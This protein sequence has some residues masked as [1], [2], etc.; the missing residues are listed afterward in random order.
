LNFVCT[1]C[2]GGGILL[3]D[4]TTQT[5]DI[6][7]DYKASQ[8]DKNSKTL[9][10]AVSD[11]HLLVGDMQLQINHYYRP[12]KNL[13]TIDSLL[14]VHPTNE[15]PILLMLQ[16]TRSTEKHDVKLSGL[17]RVNQM[18]LPPPREPI[19]TMWW[20]PL[21][22]YSRIYTFS[23]DALQTWRYTITLLTRV[24]CSCLHD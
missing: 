24:R 14:L 9:Q 20:F 23:K 7:A 21:S 22:A 19:S 12:G 1:S 17:E 5:F 8:K 2:L 18:V 13:P 16:I 15:L 11:E 3:R 6:Y 10:L 4:R